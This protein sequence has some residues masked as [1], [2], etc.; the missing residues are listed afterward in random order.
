M[1]TVFLIVWKKIL[2]KFLL[3]ANIPE[4]NSIKFKNNPIYLYIKNLNFLWKYKYH[5]IVGYQNVT[6]IRLQNCR[7]QICC[8][9]IVTWQFGNDNLV[10]LGYQFVVTKLL[11]PNLS[12]PNCHFH[13]VTKLSLPNCR[14]QIIINQIDGPKN[15]PVPFIE[16]ESARNTLELN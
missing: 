7:Y 3:G 12:L 2:K 8:Y 10:T 1:Q 9:Q 13:K 16:K 11:L 6:F 5:V 15:P 14:Y 4:L